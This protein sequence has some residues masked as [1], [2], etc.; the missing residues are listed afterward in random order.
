MSQTIWQTHTGGLSKKFIFAL[1]AAL[2][3]GP[4][5]R[6]VTWLITPLGN[7][8]ALETN[9]NI[10]TPPRLLR[11]YL[12]LSVFLEKP[13]KLCGTAELGTDV[14]GNLFLSPHPTQIREA[15]LRGCEIP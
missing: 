15:V 8:K 12:L 13:T 3:K 1:C 11:V 7:G 9:R 14:N 5:K 2:S 10:P 4:A 6:R